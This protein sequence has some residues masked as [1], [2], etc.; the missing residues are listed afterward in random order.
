MIHLLNRNAEPP[1]RYFT[2][3]DQ[4]LHDRA[5]HVRRNRETDA[6]IAAAARENSGI[7]AD[8]LAARVDQ[9]TARVAGIDRRIRLDEIFVVR[10]ADVGAA[11]RANDA[12]RDGRV[13]R[14][15]ISDGEDILAHFELVGIAPRYR[16]QILGAD[17]HHGNVGLRIGADDFADKLALVVEQNFDLVRL[18]DD[19][20]VGDD[21]TFA[22]NDH[23]AAE[24]ALFAVARRLKAAEEFI[25]EELPKE[26][27]VHERRHL[28]APALT[29]ACAHHARRRNIHYGRSHRFHDR[30]KVL[31]RSRGCRQRQPRLV[32]A[33]SGR[34]PTE[35]RTEYN[36]T[37][38]TRE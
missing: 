14:E 10:D 36:S 34:H 29:T 17:L 6:H 38:Q 31:L 13:Q 11:D 3:L 27:I 35:T 28:L 12:H 33:A 4:A 24:A 5:R 37:N 20:V 30:D 1:A 16:R 26:R 21:V 23:S 7:D 19:M 9:R 2:V 8:E 22:G 18:G 25:P 32:R 15:R